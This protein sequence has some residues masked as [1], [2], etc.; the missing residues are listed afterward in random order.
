MGGFTLAALA[1]LGQQR[2]PQFDHVTQ[3]AEALDIP[4]IVGGDIRDF[5]NWY[6]PTLLR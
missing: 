5:A 3:Q 6:R 4:L 1:F 2:A